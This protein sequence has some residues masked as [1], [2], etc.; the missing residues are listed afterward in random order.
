MQAYRLL[1]ERHRRM[2]A[3][4][5]AQSVLSWDRSTMMPAG[6]ADSRAEQ[7]AALAVLL[8]EQKTDAALGAL[9]D[10]A[11][12]ERAALDPWQTANLREMQRAW[13]HARA[14]PAELVEALSRASSAAEMRWRDAREKSDFASLA[15][16]LA[17]LVALVREEAAAKSEAFG[18]TP[19]EALLDDYDPGRKVAEIDALFAH[20]ES[21][22]PPLLE[23]VLEKQARAPAPIAPTGPFRDETQHVLGRRL[24]QILHFDF[25]HGRLD[26]SHHPFTGGV[27]DDVRITTRYRA[28]DFTS[29]VMAVIHE[30]GHAQYERGLPAAW[31][32]Q[33]VGRSLGMTLHESQ[34]LLFEMQAGRSDAFLRFAAPLFGEILE[35]SGAAWQAENLIRLYRRVSRGL[36][37]VEADEVTYPLH[38]LLRYRLERALVE[39]ELEVADL[40][41]VWN[42]EMTRLVG[43]TPPDDARGVL[44]DIH[45]PSGAFGYFPTYTLGALA[46]A[47]LFDAARRAEPDLVPGLGRGD[48]APLLAWLRAHVHGEGSLRS[49]AELIERATGAP[50]GTEVFEAHLRA[51]YLDGA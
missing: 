43:A 17:D 45:W 10:E 15:P 37:R 25:E 47:Q 16:L 12:A 18:C 5:G 28:D 33:P 3:L 42:A 11:D 24:M 51:R 9:L 48:F 41:S 46:A 14:V 20:L 26:V 22:L 49:S 31:R 6:G 21:I 38:V 13:R 44:Q 19:Y 4:A 27:P 8:H 23:A 39:K 36:I 40:P 29:S 1:E 30:T 34:S 35:G 7:M 2:S 32:G 50:L